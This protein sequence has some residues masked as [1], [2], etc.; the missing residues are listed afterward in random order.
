M[1]KKKILFIYP[2]MM[3]GGSTTSLL[4][5]LNSMDYEQYE[6]DII[7]YNKEGELINSLPKEVRVLPLACKYPDKKSMYF[8]KICSWKSI[9]TT[10]K[11]KVWGIQKKNSWL[12][13]QLGSQ[14]NVRYCR[15]LEV[16][17]DIA[18]S[19]LEFW[20]LYYLAECVEADR[21]I[22]WIHTDYSKLDLLKKYENRALAKID[23]IVLISQECR[24]KFLGCFPEWACKSMVVEN[25]VSAKYI[26][27]KAKETVDFKVAD[28]CLKFVTT[29]RIDFESKGLDRALNVICRLKEEGYTKYFQWYIIGTGEDEER[30]KDLIDKRNVLDCV[31]FLGQQNN[32]FPYEIKCD[33]FF[34]PSRF[35]GKPIAV[36]EAQILGLVPIVTDYSSA[37]EQICHMQDGIILKNQE[38]A[39]YDGVKNVL[40]NP[41]IIKKLS[42]V[43][44]EK[45]IVN[46][47]EQQWRSLLN[48]R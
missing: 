9:W 23:N 48:E 15:Q 3:L 45:K 36:T 5:V 34:L 17:Y 2:H 42:Q 18:I 21:K 20:P 35:E 1:A 14:D 29:C 24:S 4:S 44:K 12:S 27:E 37:K 10:I 16:H 11:G 43:I 7:F 13:H 47:G 8:Q 31:F 25:F 41:D 26:K 22:A 19:Y 30:L 32:P 39:I 28:R 40:C 33:V 46:N 38:E 6:T